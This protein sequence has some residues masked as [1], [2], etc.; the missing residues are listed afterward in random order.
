MIKTALSAKID[1]ILLTQVDQ[2]AHQLKIPRN[3]ALAEGLKLWVEVKSREI[4]AAKMKEAS[5]ATRK[6]SQ[7]IAKDWESTLADGLDGNDQK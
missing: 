6:E 3:R 4:L 7:S 1:Q 5:L 2:I